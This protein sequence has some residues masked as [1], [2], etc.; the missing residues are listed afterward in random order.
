VI[1]IRPGDTIHTPPG[2]WHWHG[3]APDH[4]LTHLAMWEAP[5]DPKPERPNGAS[6]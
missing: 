2:D 5:T 1:E 6:S 3:A 4:F